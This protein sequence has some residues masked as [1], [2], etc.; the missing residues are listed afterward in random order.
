MHV[1]T[2]VEVL[3]PAGTLLV[4]FI[5]EHKEALGIRGAEGTQ[6]LIDALV[7]V[8]HLI[9]NNTHNDDICY[10]LVLKKVHLHGQHAACQNSGQGDSSGCTLMLSKVACLR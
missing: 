2:C 7:A 4:I 3:P 6:P 9:Q 1:V 5:S 10:S 8:L